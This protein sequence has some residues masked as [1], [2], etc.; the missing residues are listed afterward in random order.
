MLFSKSRALARA[1]SEQRE[2]DASAAALKNAPRMDKDLPLGIQLHGFIE[3]NSV[4]YFLLED[5]GIAAKCPD[6]KQKVIAY[7]RLPIPGGMTQ[8]RFYLDNDFVLRVVTQDDNVVESETVVFAKSEV[9][10]PNGEDDWGQ[11]LGNESDAPQKPGAKE[12]IP[13]SIIGYETYQVGDENSPLYHRLVEADDALQEDAHYLLQPQIRPIIGQE[14]YFI[15]PYDLNG[16]V[17]NR[18]LMFYGRQIGEEDKPT[19]EFVTVSSV[20]IGDDAWVESFT[21]IR[22]GHSDLTII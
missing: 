9:H 21:G 7:G 12:T 4:P 5:H 18:H 14:T 6:G 20:A 22:A 19:D 3:V 13:R 15:D 10:Y 2:K 17:A 11:W 8:H 1:L 16:K